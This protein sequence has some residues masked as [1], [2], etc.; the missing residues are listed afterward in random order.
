MGKQFEACGC[1]L[2]ERGRKR[3]LT[4]RRFDGLLAWP[5]VVVAI[6]NGP[7]AVFVDQS[8][9]AIGHRDVASS[10]A[11]KIVPARQRGCA[12]ADT[13]R[14]GLVLPGTQVPAQQSR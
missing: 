4:Q 2:E 7:V 3:T 9:E 1:R 10:W 8:V 5:T 12:S 14:R 6:V 11:G 13:T